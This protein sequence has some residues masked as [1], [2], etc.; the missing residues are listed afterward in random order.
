ML[1]PE[2]M[3]RVSVTGS[4]RVMDDVIEAVHDLHLL[5][6]TEYAG[7]W[8]G[9][10]HGNPISGAD[11]AAEK[12]VTVRSLESILDVDAEDAGPTRVVSDEALE[13]DLAEIRERVNELDDRRSEI[14]SELREIE[15]RIEGMEPF[16]DLGIDLDLLSGYDS[17]EVSVGEGKRDLVEDA[18]ASSSAVRNHRV[19]A[20]DDG[21]TLGVFA[22]PTEDGSL[23]DAV[24]GTE[25]AAVTIPDVSEV[26]DD[27]KG[28]NGEV[29][30]ETYVQELQSRRRKL[31][32]RLDTVDGELEEVKLDAAGFLLAAEEKLSIE[33]QKT[34]APLTFA[35]TDNAFV[36][37]G[38]IP[39]ARYGD[40]V[41]VPRRGDPA[42]GDEGVV[43]RRE[44]QRRFGLLDLDR[45]LLLRGEEEARRVEFDLL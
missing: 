1:R 15:E 43:G 41:A 39:T 31:Q 29:P 21:S 12:L 26:P 24:V 16:V 36:A 35:T 27:V 23:S 3:S 42:L 9:F 28:P 2:Q 5:H 40:E 34:E 7:D 45:E 8:E 14:D 32:S 4:K 22:R 13:A 33:V 6:V 37:E 11:R 44:R 17:I 25:F 38:W 19:F 10:D 20:S 18:L 30:P